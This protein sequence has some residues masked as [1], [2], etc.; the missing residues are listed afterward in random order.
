MKFKNKSDLLHKA[1]PSYLSNG[2]CDRSG[3]YVPEDDA[4]KGDFESNR[5]YFNEG[6]TF[7]G[8]KRWVGI[9]PEHG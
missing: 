8:Q 3:H 4:E 9:P 2:V 7:P 5:R 1:S 6:D